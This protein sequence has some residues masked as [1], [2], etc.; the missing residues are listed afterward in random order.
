[1][2]SN[3]VVHHTFDLSFAGYRKVRC[4]LFADGL[5]IETENLVPWPGVLLRG[6]LDGIPSK[7]VRT[8]PQFPLDAQEWFPDA[9]INAAGVLLL[10]HGAKP[11]QN[12]TTQGWAEMESLLALCRIHAA[13][14]HD[15]RP[16]DRKFGTAN[17]KSLWHNGETYVRLADLAEF[18]RMGRL[19]DDSI[20][21]IIPDPIDCEASS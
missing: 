3:Q 5:W 10:F 8:D 20:S 4:H 9:Q 6:G 1:M 18:I 2:N 15:I 16:H 12:Y 19:L 11:T 21:G 13:V 14:P 17:V 7:C